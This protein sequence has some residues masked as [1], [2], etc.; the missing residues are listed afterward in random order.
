VAYAMH[1]ETGGERNAADVVPATWRCAEPA[2]IGACCRCLSPTRATAAAAAA[3]TATIV[4]ARDAVAVEKRR[5]KRR[6]QLRGERGLPL[7]QTYKWCVRFE[8]QVFAAIR[9][10]PVLLLRYCEGYCINT[11]CFDAAH[12]LV[13]V[14]SDD[15]SA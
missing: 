15:I 8:S 5:I 9:N 1:V 12:T 4:T 3:T 6:R 11:A 13:T 2:P 14:L 10:Q 7:P